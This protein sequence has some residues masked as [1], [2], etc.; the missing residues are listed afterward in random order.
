M[1]FNPLY[2]II[3]IT[4]IF[5]LYFCSNLLIDNGSLLAKK[6]NISKIIIG[7]TVI[8]FGTSLPEFV[9]SMLAILQG[10]IDLVVGNVLG[11]NIANIGLV[12]GVSGI[13]YSM[14]CNFK[15]IKLDSIFL[16]ISSLIF[17]VIL[18]FQKFEYIYGFLLFLV[19][20]IYI[21]ILRKSNKVLNNDSN[22]SYSHSSVKLL[23]VV[24]LGSIG[25]SIGSFCLIEGASEIAEYFNV[26]E[27]IIGITAVALGTSLP[28][29]VTSLNAASRNEFELVI[30][31][32]F[33][34]NIFNIIF[35]FSTSLLINSN[36]PQYRDYSFD[37][38][39]FLL[40]TVIMVL[41]LLFGKAYRFISLLLLIIYMYY[42]SSIL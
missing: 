34:S 3:F 12:I 17:S 41:S 9:V 40:L 25:L 8:A 42:I 1:T 32:I 13:I 36:I 20:F 23:M 10:K 37:L 31:N 6:Y 26:S 39:I 2:I 16:L 33:G 30:G 21:Y 35:V 18:F 4:G 27:M 24:L 14:K 5:L 22:N 28:E 7:M 19:L 15:K 38:F 11:S 29:L